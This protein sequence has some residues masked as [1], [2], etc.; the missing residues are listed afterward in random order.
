MSAKS[1]WL[2]IIGAVV[3][4]LVT[5]P[6]D[7]ELMSSLASTVRNQ[8]ASTDAIALNKNDSFL[9]G[10]SKF[11]CAIEMNTCANLI[12]ASLKI[13]TNDFG[14]MRSATAKNSNGKDIFIC[15]GAYK[16]WWCR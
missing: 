16:N 14:P 3:V 7:Q 9:S 8:L 13:T 1:E 15:L 12:L 5:K 2:L 4:G 11:G 6:T 10:L